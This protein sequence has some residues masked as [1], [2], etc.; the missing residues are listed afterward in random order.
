MNKN[1]ISI[2]DRQI[3]NNHPPFI[4]AEMSGN[5][6][7]SLERALEIVEI[8][9]KTGV[10][11]LKIQTYTADTMTLDLDRDEFFIND[12]KSLWYGKSLFELYQQAYTPWE[13]HKPVFDRCREL[14]II[15]FSTPFDFTAVDFLESLDVPFYKIASFENTDLPLIR[16]VASTGKP[17]IISTGMATIA[18]LDETITTAKQA[19]CQNLILLKCTSSYPSTPKDTNLL[20]IPHLRD[21]FDDIQVGLSDHTLGIGVAVASVAL[22][23]TVIEKHFTL[24][25][26]DGGVDAAFSME[27]QEMKQL[28]IETERAWQAMG[29]ISYGVTAAEQ[30]SL[31]FRR[32]LYIAQNMQSGD[33]LTSDN[34]RA[35]RPGQGLPPKYYNLLLG[36]KIKV[37]VQA[38]TPVKWELLM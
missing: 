17:I 28:V 25:R 7:Q 6:N 21:L 24:N 15:G 12:P 32:S 30:K 20:T 22:G 34:L 10:H 5:H 3:G 18:E 14:G 13:W 36:K 9:A 4:I 33:I 37:D 26:A 11:A 19:G 27:P 29:K 35:I 23:A 1:S 8:A 31:I 16:K 38:G 2:S